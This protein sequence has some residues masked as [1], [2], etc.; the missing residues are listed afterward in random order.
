MRE[1]ILQWKAATFE[2]ATPCDPHLTQLYTL[3]NIYNLTS[4]YIAATGPIPDEKMD[5]LKKKLT[6][7]G[8]RPPRIVV[9]LVNRLDIEQCMNT[10]E[11]LAS[12]ADV[13]CI[14]GGPDA[15]CTALAIEAK[16]HGKM[17]CF[18]VDPRPTEMRKRKPFE[19]LRLVN[20]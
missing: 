14:S 19:V 5:L 7:E 8:P 3:V 15:L 4:L 17:I 12:R 18:V 11:D 6:M 9:S 2:V 20:V 16:T 10:A 1:L 13:V